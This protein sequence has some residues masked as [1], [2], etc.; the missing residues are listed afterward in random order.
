MDPWFSSKTRQNKQNIIGVWLKNTNT[1]K[2]KHKTEKGHSLNAK[3]IKK[4]RINWF[5]VF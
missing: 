2:F 3:E 5:L 1:E 4:L